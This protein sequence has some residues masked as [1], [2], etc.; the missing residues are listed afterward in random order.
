MKDTALGEGLVTNIALGFMLYLPLNSHFELYVYFIQTGSSALSN[1]QDTIVWR[2][3]HSYGETVKNRGCSSLH[4]THASY[5][6]VI[7]H[8]AYV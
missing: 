8:N 4:S 2:K 3:S 6:Y 5:A 1:T 7:I